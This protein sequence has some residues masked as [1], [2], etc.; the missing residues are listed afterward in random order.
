MIRSTVEYKMS[1]AELKAAVFES[2]R[3][4]IRELISLC[5]M[6]VILPNVLEIYKIYSCLGNCSQ[7]L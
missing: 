2:V 5:Y 3:D 4:G 7:W 1:R 6:V